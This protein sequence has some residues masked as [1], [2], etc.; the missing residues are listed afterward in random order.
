LVGARRDRCFGEEFR[1]RRF[2]NTHDG[3][4]RSERFFVE[5]ISVL[6]SARRKKLLI[7]VLLKALDFDSHVLE[8]AFGFG[9]VELG[10]RDRLRAAVADQQSPGGMK[11]VALGVPAK[12]VVI[13][14]NQHARL[15]SGL[16]TV[17][18]GSRQTADSRADD[19]QIIRIRVGSGVV[20]ALSVAQRMRDLPRSIVASA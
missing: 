13:V 12:I 11:L 9:T 6:Q 1:P 16:F 4:V 2:S 8:E 15:W 7:V 10:S 19:D 17:E 18:I 3:A 20:P 14:E 5:E